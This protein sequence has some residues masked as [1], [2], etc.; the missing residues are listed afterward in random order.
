MQV[1]ISDVLAHYKKK[2]DES[3][4]RSV[5]VKM[6]NVQKDID[7][8]TTAYIQAV[9]IRNELL[10]KGCESRMQEL[11][12]LLED[13]QNQHSKLS[14]ERGLMLSEKDISSFIAEF[15]NG[16]IESKDFQKQVIDNLVNAVYA[17]DSRLVIYFA[18]KG[19]GK[20][21]PI[22]SLADTNTTTNQKATSHINATSLVSN[23]TSP[24]CSG[25]IAIG[26]G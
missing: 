25:S 2:T 7:N 11:S 8:A 1:V 9:T 22:I 3:E 6:H 5:E 26:G 13:L 4:L 10:Q 21:V 18:I 12:A 24:E 16:N 20:A 23:T 15:I 17:Y 14:L 19:G